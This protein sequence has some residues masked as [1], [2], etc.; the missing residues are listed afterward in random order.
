MF[1]NKRSDIN[2]NKLVKQVCELMAYNLTLS[3]SPINNVVMLSCDSDKRREVCEAN[4]HR[5]SKVVFLN[6]EMRKSYGND[7]ISENC[8]WQ[9]VTF[10]FIFV[11]LF[12]LMLNVPV[13]R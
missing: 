3:I 5:E 10:Y 6:S 13:N 7:S 12:E 8:S 11:C 2:K 1:V 9:S 4:L